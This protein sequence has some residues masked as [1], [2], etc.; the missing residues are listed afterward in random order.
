MIELD[1]ISIFYNTSLLAELDFAVV[2]AVNDGEALNVVAH[3][4]QA[5]ASALEALL[6]DKAHTF[7][8]CTGLTGKVNHAER[9]ISIGKEVVDENHM[10]VLRQEAVA[11]ANRIYTIFG[12]RAHFRHEHIVH[13]FRLFFL[14]EHHRQL[15]DIAQHDGWSDTAG[16]NGYNLIEIHPGKTAFELLGDFVHQIRVKLMVQKAVHL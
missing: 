13:R 2:E 14:D 5:V 1:M 3:F 6:D 11:D 7:N 10:V 15:K 16:L 8:R 12:E 4:A 9:S